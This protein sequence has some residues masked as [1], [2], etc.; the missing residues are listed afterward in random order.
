MLLDRNPGAEG[1]MP[2][3]AVE[4]WFMVGLKRPLFRNPRLV[5]SW[6]SS[7]LYS[8]IWSDG[9]M[10]EVTSTDGCPAFTASV[11]LDTA[12]QARTFKWGVILDGPQGANFWGIPTEVQDVNSTERARQF[13]LD[14][15]TT[16]P[17]VER[18]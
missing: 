11:L 13:Q 15:T 17:Q 9:T 6:D 14:T 5:G 4:F 7:V 2:T 18:Y 3:Q 1:L 12:D 10:P 16:G 8:D